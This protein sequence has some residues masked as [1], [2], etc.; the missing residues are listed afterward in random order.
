MSPTIAYAN[1]I[2]S[3]VG[4]KSPPQSPYDKEIFQTT[5]QDITNAGWAAM[6]NIRMPRAEGTG[7]LERLSTP[8][9]CQT[10][11]EGLSRR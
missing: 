3:E 4:A 10:A 9:R 7:G 11:P 8:V 2:S 1:V 6:R 5:N